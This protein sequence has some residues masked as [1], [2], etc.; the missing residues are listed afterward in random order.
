MAGSTSQGVLQALTA[1]HPDALGVSG[2]K[3]NHLAK[4]NTVYVACWVSIIWEVVIDAYSNDL[5]NY[6]LVDSES[7]SYQ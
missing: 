6:H 2:A 4:A 5:L 1:P 7:N 3:E